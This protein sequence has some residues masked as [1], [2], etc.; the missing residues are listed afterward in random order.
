MG[1]RRRAAVT[2]VTC[3]AVPL[4]TVTACSSNAPPGPQSV[5]N[6]YLSDWAEENWQAMRQLSYAPPADFIAVNTAAF[7]DL[8]VREATFTG[9]N[10]TSTSTSAS[11]EV[12]ER[13]QLGGLGSIVLTTTLSLSF[14]QGSWRVDW[15][16]STI[17][18]QL[19]QG[20]HLKV[21]T[22]WPKR[23]PI[24][25]ANRTALA[26]HGQVV[27][28]G[29]EGQRVKN[30]AKVRSALIRA[31][32]PTTEVS[33]AMTA[34]KAKPKEFEPVFTVTWARYLQLKPAIYP[35][36]GTVFQASRQWQAITPGLASGLVGEMG[37]IT[38]Q[39]LSRLG[40]PYN[41]QN[42]IGQTGL[43]AAEEHQLAGT[44][45]IKV[46]VVNASGASVATIASNPAEPG[47]PVRTTIDPATQ[48]AA[49]AAL[50]GEA[51]SASLVAVN[52]STGAVLAAASVNAGGFDQA[53]AGGFPP[54]SA[55]K[56][57]TSTA[58]IE[59][60]LTPSS[61]ASCPTTSRVD[62]KV[63]HNAEGDS[64][65]ATMT[66]A[67]AESCNT[68]FINLARNH[69]SAA[70]FPVTAAQYDIG[71][72]MDLGLATFAGSVPQPVNGAD[73]AATAIG[74]SRVLVN[75]LDMAMVA[76]AV[77]TGTVHEP[78]LV[79]N[80]SATPVVT[81]QLPANV[82]AGLHTMMA[83]V[84]KSGTA[85]GQGLPS[86]TYAKTGT[87]EYGTTKPLKLD[88][89]LVGFRGD[90]AFACLVVN[91]PGDGGPA[92][93]PLVAKFLAGLDS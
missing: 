52:A 24:L 32:A 89:W 21:T 48:K 53:I 64:P 59:H 83:A 36:P 15:A 62:G 23:A 45:G 14:R 7:K 54:G 27:T 78:T 6:I 19:Y 50:D 81:S 8:G 2:L 76:A 88:A 84:V 66:Q 43:E 63:F 85:A 42:V 70:D 58:L 38:A 65:V 82:V 61:S 80:P 92:C 3:V 22:L 34:A 13:F 67:F 10:L 25:A 74:Q 5:A 68:A 57:V 16:P 47:A 1:Y 41:A 9:Q 35:I 72:P 86:G 77:D 51:K 55:F 93:G 44:A 30:A 39:E 17:A 49:E 79:D 91:S 11:E 20:D 69:L 26:T 28:I 90:I 12:I 75:P 73:F 40:A 4:L 87:A 71:K 18:R 33:Q 46:T 29:V 56:I 37:P 31:G 60:G